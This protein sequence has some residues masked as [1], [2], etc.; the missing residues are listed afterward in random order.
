MEIEMLEGVEERILQVR[1]DRMEE[2]CGEEVFY[3]NELPGILPPAVHIKDGKTVYQ[4]HIGRGISLREWMEKRSLTVTDVHRLMEGINLALTSVSDFFLSP[5]NLMIWIDYVFYDEEK[6]TFHIPYVSGFEGEL[7]EELAGIVERMMDDLDHMDKELLFLV[8]GLHKICKSPGFHMGKIM[9][10]I[11]KDQKKA[12]VNEMTFAP[13]KS[14]REGRTNPGTENRGGEKKRVFQGDVRNE[15]VEKKEK[16]EKNGRS[17]KI[18]RKEGSEKNER[19]G[20]KGNYGLYVLLMASV[21]VMGLA[22]RGGV[23]Q[24]A[25]GGLNLSRTLGLGLL[26]VGAFAY[27][28]YRQREK[29]DEEAVIAG[30]YVPE[31]TLLATDYGDE[32]VLLSD[33]VSETGYVLNL[34]PND[35][36]RVEMQIRKSPFFIGKD[37]TKVDGVIAEGEV[38]RVHVKVVSE[39]GGIFMIDQEST[40]GTFVNGKRFTPW[41]RTRILNGDQISIAGIGYTAEIVESL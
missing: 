12:A 19:E 32:T 4:Y 36:H 38:S 27:Y 13:G 30:A 3:Y 10:F 5:G 28:Y 33:M 40:N 14:R 26:L 18:G 34:I 29:K 23:L 17:G 15:E 6:Q 2:S 22:Y 21:V 8:Y 7:S 25:D 37:G 9:D 16:K 39:E 35:W 1:M 41:E 11:G 24:E 31:T 20:K